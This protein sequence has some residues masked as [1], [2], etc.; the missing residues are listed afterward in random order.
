L[1]ETPRPRGYDKVAGREG[2]LRIWAGRDLRVLYKVDE[3]AGRPI[4]VAIRK[5]DESSNN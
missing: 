5:K 2:Q 3:R 4:I 1:Q